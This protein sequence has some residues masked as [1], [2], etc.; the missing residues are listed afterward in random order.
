MEPTLQIFDIQER[1]AGEV[2]PPSFPTPPSSTANG[3]PAHKKRTSAFKQ[4]RQAGAQDAS[5]KSEQPTAGT[6]H[7]HSMRYTDS[8]MM[9]EKRTVDEENQARLASMSPEEIMEA[10]KELFSSL[11]P[12]LVQMLL[13]RSNLDERSN[14]PD[15]FA[16][17]PAEGA[18]Q[19]EPPEIKVEDTSKGEKG[20]DAAVTPAKP[21]TKKPKKTVTFDEDA[22]PAVPPEDLFPISEPP[23]KTKSTDPDHAHAHSHNA[24]HFPTAPPLPDLDPADPNFLE[25][26]HK[27]YFPSLP[28]DPSRL[29]WMAPVPTEGS[30]A[31]QESPYYPDQNSLPVSALRFDF[32]GILLPPHKSRQ[33]PVDKGLHHHGEAPEAAGYTI[34]ELARLA[35]S[36]VPGQRCIAYQTLGRMLYRLGQGEWG[37]GAGGRGGDEDDLAFGLWRCFQEGR[38]LE[39]LGEEAAQP[40]GK[41]HRSAKAFATEALWLLEKGGWKEKWRG[42]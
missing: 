21:E 36:A 42:M 37:T 26:L 4:R 15:I 9:S 39:T 41:G 19:T 1:A 12:K 20:D 32:R 17:S 16:S 22:A 40:E 13:R 29:A 14:E 11:D 24:T 10:Q 23:P 7:Q 8:P 31:D 6:S 33:I 18:P 25:N 38:V 5:T 28:A 34:P 2:K 27:K 3:F 30:L 35:R